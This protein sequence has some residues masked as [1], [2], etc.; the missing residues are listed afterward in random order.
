[1]KKKTFKTITS[2]QDTKSGNLYNN[3]NFSIVV[4]LLW[5]SNN[6]AFPHDLTS[7]T[8]FA[9]VAHASRVDAN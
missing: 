9:T 3:N 7:R 1:M 2:K 5:E 4:G 8:G 6:I